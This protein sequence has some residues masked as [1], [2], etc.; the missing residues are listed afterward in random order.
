MLKLHDDFLAPLRIA[1][2]F[3]LDR[4]SLNSYNKSI[5]GSPEKIDATTVEA[6][7][8]CGRRALKE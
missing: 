2:P 3:R 7:A 5:K 6:G 1:D 8:R 4:W